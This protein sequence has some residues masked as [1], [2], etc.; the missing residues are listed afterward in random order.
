[1]SK[2]IKQE[3]P[4]LIWT[5]NVMLDGR[6]TI[7]RDA[8]GLIVIPALGGS[9]HHALVRSMTSYLEGEGFAVL[10]ADLLTSDEQ[11]FDTRTGH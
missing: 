2:L 6:L 7:P 1:M 4:V 8:E 5:G 3:E 9:F 11:Q 10:A